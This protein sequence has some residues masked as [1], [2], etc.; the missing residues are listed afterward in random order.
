MASEM[1][2]WLQGVAGS[3]G[4]IVANAIVYPLDII[5]TR[6][7]VQLNDT[8]SEK[9][10]DKSTRYKGTLDALTKILEEEGCSGLYSGLP[11]CSIGVAS[12]NF[13]YFYAYSWLKTVLASNG[14]STTTV[15]G[16]LG[17]GTAAGAITSL[18]ITPISTVTTRQQTSTKR[19]QSMLATTKEI[20]SGPGGWTALWNG[21]GASLI[22]SINPAIT[23]GAYSRLRVLL[24]ANR[25]SLKPHETF[26]KWDGHILFSSSIPLDSELTT[27]CSSRGTL[28]DDCY[29][30]HAAADCGEGDAPVSQ[31]LRQAWPAFQ[32]V[33]RGSLLHCQE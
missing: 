7:Q 12:T 9:T 31:G 16:D 29:L 17:L 21:I 32:V 22:L 27:T 20:V 25:K 3:A 33:P 8:D 19:G 13:V 26:R 10:S 6:L 24:F 28:Q 1:P 14:P 15:A 23:Y 5:K 4:G 11:G 2:P 18:A 30:C